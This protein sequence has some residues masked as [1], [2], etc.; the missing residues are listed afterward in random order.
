M[1]AQVN[2]IVFLDFY[3]LAKSIWL[4]FPRFLVV[5]CW[6]IIR[7]TFTSK[8]QKIYKKTADFKLLNKKDHLEICKSIITTIFTLTRSGRRILVAQ[9]RLK[10]LGF[11]ALRLY[12]SYLYQ[13]WTPT[14]YTE[15]TLK[16]FI[17]GLCSFFGFFKG[18]TQFAGAVSMTGRRTLVHL[19]EINLKTKMCPA[20]WSILAPPH[21]ILQRFW[22]S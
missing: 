5:K 12:R 19:Y 20:A 3:L 13:H 17:F 18:S 4:W 2:L 11:T 6:A 15:K 21:F 14:L 8:I 7:T 16:S 10:A 1:I 22:R 9:E